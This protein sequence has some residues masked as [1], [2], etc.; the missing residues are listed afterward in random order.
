MKICWKIKI[1]GTRKIKRLTFLN[2][3]GVYK[4]VVEKKMCTLG[5]FKL[6][7]ARKILRF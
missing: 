7:Y 4:I 2:S 6:S 3:V 5:K 1:V